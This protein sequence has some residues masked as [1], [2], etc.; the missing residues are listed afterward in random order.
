[1]VILSIQQHWRRVGNMLA[2]V[3]RC[4]SHSVFLWGYKGNA[5]EYISS[6][7]E[8]N[9]LDRNSKKITKKE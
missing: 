7:K 1:M 4:K 8:K 3:R 6:I 5:Y 2:D 9:K